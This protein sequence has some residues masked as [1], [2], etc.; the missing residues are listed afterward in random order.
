MLPKINPNTIE[1]DFTHLLTGDM[2][3]LTSP[4]GDYVIDVGW[5]PD[6]NPGGAYVCVIIKDNDW[7]VPLT[8]MMSRSYEDVIKWIAGA[9]TQVES[10]V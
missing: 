7:Q 8:R 10:W 1:G 2:V 5:L 4:G 6:S 9:V 3:Q